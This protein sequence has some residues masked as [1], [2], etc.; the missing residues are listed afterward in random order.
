VGQAEADPARHA[1]DVGG[2]PRL[3]LPQLRR[4]AGA[5]LAAG[6]VGDHHPHPGPG[7][8]RQHAPAADLDVVRV[9][10][11]GQDVDAHGPSRW[12]TSSVGGS[13]PGRGAEVRSGGIQAGIGRPPITSV[14]TV[15]S[16]SPY[17]AVLRP[18]IQPPAWSLWCTGSET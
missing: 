13:L 1:Q 3:L 4:A 9:R 2:P 12:S 8:Q 11:H 17:R 5:E 16:T 10:P 18:T 7:A 15:L 14:I 6:E